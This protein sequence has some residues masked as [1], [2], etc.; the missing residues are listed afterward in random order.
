[1]KTLLQIFIIT[2][3]ILGL[4]GGGWWLYQNQELVIGVFDTTT[5]DTASGFTQIVA[6]T[7]G[8]LTASLSVVGE[9]AAVQQ[10][11]LGF[12]RLSGTA[13]LIDLTV[14]AGNQVEAGQILATIDPVAYQQA[15]DQAQSAL[16]E[17]E[18]SLA[19]LNTTATELDIAL[20]DLAITQ[21]ELDLAQAEADLADLDDPAA[22][23]DLTDLQAAVQAAQDDLTL[24]QVQYA[25]TEHNS[26]AK[27]ERDLAYAA[28]WHDRRIWEVRDLISSG[29]ANLEQTNELT[30]EQDA[31]AQAKADLARIQAQRQ[32]ALQTANTEILAA[33][34]ALA[35]ANSALADAQAGSTDALAAAKAQVAVQSAKVALQ[36]AQDHR[37]TLED[38]PDTAD[39]ASA[40]AA[41]DKQRLAVTTAQANLDGATLVAPFAG[42][43]LQVNS[44][45]GSRITANSTVLTLANLDTLQVLA[46]VDETTIRQVSAGQAARITF[47]AFPG[48]TFSG[49][50][51]SVPLQGTLQGGV[52]VYEVAISLEEAGDLP[53]LVGMTANVSVLT[54]QVENALLVPSMAI[55][56]VNGL[57]QVLVPGGTDPLVS[58]ISVPVEVGLSDGTYTQI[59]RG[60]VPGDSV[61]IQLS[62]ATTTNAFF[63]GGGGTGAVFGGGVTGGFGR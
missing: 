35:E 14:A 54:G 58:P 47:D 40:Q 21:A 19:D 39:L 49:Q 6:A 22:Q 9:M 38:G 51:L 59:L 43:V 57:N 63:G 3:L 4:A 53:L 15:L 16:Q 26:L 48:Q 45:T 2:L 32:L 61:V 62:T 13:T 30:T 1:M 36:A 5:T 24:A 11:D 20:A 12:D 56:T 52:M 23:T 50:V 37:Q 34:S 33:Q 17:A 18:Q 46:S 60:L 42:T 31:L 44:K 28:D 41:V 25:L 27:S 55:L 7:Q 8:D 29:Q 10:V